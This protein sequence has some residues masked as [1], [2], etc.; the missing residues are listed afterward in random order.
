MENLH[1]SCEVEQVCCGYGLVNIYNF[2]CS[3]QKT[4]NVGD[5]TPEQVQ[6]FV[7]RDY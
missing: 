6:K 1:G 3:S 7:L 2:L 5:L 4:E